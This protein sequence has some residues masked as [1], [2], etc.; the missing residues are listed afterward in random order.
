MLTEGRHAEMGQAIGLV[1]SCMKC[2]QL[3][4]PHPTL[5]LIQPTNASLAMGNLFSRHLTGTYNNTPATSCVLVHSDG[6]VSNMFPV[7]CATSLLLRVTDVRP[8]RMDNGQLW[9]D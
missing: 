1:R 4:Q 2:S 9:V 6:S 5:T 3:E 7:S 8:G